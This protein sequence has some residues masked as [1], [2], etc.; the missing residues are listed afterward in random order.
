MRAMSRRMISVLRALGVPA[1]PCI[2]T[3]SRMTALRRM[4]LTF[5]SISLSTS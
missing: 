5:S 3:F 2:S 4:V 1:S